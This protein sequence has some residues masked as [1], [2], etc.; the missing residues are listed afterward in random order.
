MQAE[1]DQPIKTFTIGFEDAQYD[2]AKDA[3]AVAAHIGSGPQN[4]LP[5]AQQGPRPD[6]SV[7]E[8]VRRALCRTHRRL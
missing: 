8:L 2:E 6:P 5:I 3:R 7:A 4:P 1:S